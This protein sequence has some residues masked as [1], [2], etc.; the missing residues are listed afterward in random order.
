MVLVP[1]QYG[2][3]K[4]AT[5]LRLSLSKLSLE[6]IWWHGSTIGGF[7][8]VVSSFETGQMK[9]EWN[10]NEAGR[11]IS[12][13]ISLL[14]IALF[15]DFS[16]FKVLSVHDLTWAFVLVR[17]SLS[18]SMLCLSVSKPANSESESV[19]MFSNDRLPESLSI[20]SD[21]DLKEEDIAGGGYRN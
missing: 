9:M 19:T 17:S 1:G 6:M 12:N 5:L 21:N 3:L 8:G 16:F 7:S 15:I 2:H 14:L 18:F 4:L 11:L 13:G 20:S 10:C